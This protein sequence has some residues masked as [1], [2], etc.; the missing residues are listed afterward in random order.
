M[1]F[2][3]FLQVQSYLP[4]DVFLYGNLFSTLVRPWAALNAKLSIWVSPDERGEP[5]ALQCSR[6]RKSA[7]PNL[8]L[9]FGLLW[10][11]VALLF[12]FLAQTF[13]ELCTLTSLKVV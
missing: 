13:L 5:G 12:E 11:H 8:S 1:S 4:G 9:N 10:E 7:A 6:G 2:G 3:F